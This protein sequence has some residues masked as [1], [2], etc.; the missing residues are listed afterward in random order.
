MQL[1]DLTLPSPE[2]NLALD[3]AL[4]DLA[5]AAPRPCELLRLWEP[6]RPL[7]VIGRSS[8]VAIEVHQQNCGDHQIP[9]LRRC[10]G[11]AA[12]VTGRGCLMYAVVLSYQQR[13]QLAM[14]DEAHRFVLGTVVR[15]LARIG[16]AARHQG[17][18]DLTV[19]ERKFSGNSMRC[20]RTHLLYH[21][22]LLYDFPLELIGECLATPPRQPEYRAGRDHRSFVG[23]LTADVSDLR[24]ALIA[25]WQATERLETWPREL[26]ELLVREKYTTD[27]WNLRR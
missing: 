5:E 19:D 27:A 21:G 6:D 14:I 4:L 13:P 12:I 23:N 22:T 20:K 7:V 9:V 26:T 2:E 16:V 11:G 1:L 3:E 24:R 25:E 15:A 18:S 8:Q 17:S 10:S